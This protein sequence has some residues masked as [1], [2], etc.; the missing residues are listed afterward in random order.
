MILKI[1]VKYWGLLNKRTECE[2]CHMIN[3][4]TDLQSMEWD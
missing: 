1:R 4:K 3:S 2:T